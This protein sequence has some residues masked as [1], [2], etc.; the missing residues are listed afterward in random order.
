MFFSPILAT[1]YRLQQPLTIVYDQGSFVVTLRGLGDFIPLVSPTNPKVL[2]HVSH[3]VSFHLHSQRRPNATI[4]EPRTREVIYPPPPSTSVR[5]C[6]QRRRA[7]Q[8]TAKHISHRLFTPFPCA[9]L[10]VNRSGS[11]PFVHAEFATITRKIA[12]ARAET[13]SPVQLLNT[14]DSEKN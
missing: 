11:H 7:A 13:R 3:C 4:A 2:L 12:F 5:S 10:R 14:R 9:I 1:K 6:N 8:Q